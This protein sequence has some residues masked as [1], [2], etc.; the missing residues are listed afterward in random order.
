MCHLATPSGVAAGAGEQTGFAASS[1]GFIR[2][3][4]FSGPFTTKLYLAHSVRLASDSCLKLVEGDG[5][6]LNC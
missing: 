6:W 4:V 3:L 5:W 1:P 2:S